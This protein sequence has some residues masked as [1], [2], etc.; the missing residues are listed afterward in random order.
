MNVI[1]DTNVLIR[2][3]LFDDVDQGQTAR[4]ILASAERI[5]ISQHA[6]CEMVWVLRSRYKMSKE[7]VLQA[8]MALIAT[9]NVI[10]DRSAI[11]AGLK[12]MNAGADFA[13][14][15]I[16]HDGRWMGGEI[17]VSFDKKAVAAVEQE[18]F[19]AKLLRM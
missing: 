4:T 14:G 6:L 19:P 3:A 16:A 18:G 10:V 1:P 15:V 17:F 5:L 12:A 13:D 8:V 7:D 2:A 9:E 11:E